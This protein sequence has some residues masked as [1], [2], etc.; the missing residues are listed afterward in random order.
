MEETL[1]TILA[2]DPGN[3]Q[4]GYAVLE[5]PEFR[6]IKFGK[7]DN[8]ALL[9]LVAN[10]DVLYDV[11]AVAIEMVANYGMAVGREVFE[12]CV[13]IGR[14]YQAADHPN[15]HYVYR[16]EEKEILCGSLRAKDANIRQALIDR[17]AKHD[18]KNGKGTK[19]NP[20]VFYGVSKDVW[21]A[22]A[23]GVTYYEL[24]RKGCD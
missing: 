10:A 24:T 15:T 6:L 9:A 1:M 21:A 20:D 2:L 7:A 8:T 23:V 11:D 19:A 12:T 4:T 3:T 22:I 13:W 14:F 5:M 17:Y 18:L 16:K